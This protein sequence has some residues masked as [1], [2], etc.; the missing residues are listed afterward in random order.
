MTIVK[1]FTSAIEAMMHHFHGGQVPGEDYKQP[2]EYHSLGGRGG[3]RRDANG[4]LLDKKGHVIGRNE[5]FYGG[6]VAN[7][8]INPFT[9][10]RYG[11]W[12]RGSDRN[13]PIRY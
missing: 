7:S 5:A 9:G 13:G 4:N 3:G 12:M 2:P 1:K 6:G 8:G 11:S 10:Q